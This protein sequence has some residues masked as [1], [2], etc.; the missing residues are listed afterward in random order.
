VRASFN[1]T[2]TF[3]N[4]FSPFVANPLADD[5]DGAFAAAFQVTR[6]F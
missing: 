1:S 3:A 2:G 4:M 5:S 6:T